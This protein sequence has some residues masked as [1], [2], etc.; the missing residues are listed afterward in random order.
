MVALGKL[1]GIGWYRSRRGRDGP[2]QLYS[3]I[4]MAGELEGHRNIDLFPDLKGP[5]KRDVFRRVSVFIY[6]RSRYRDGRERLSVLMSAGPLVE[7]HGIA[8]I[9]R[10]KPV[11]KPSAGWATRDLNGNV[12]GSGCKFIGKRLSRLRAGS[13]RLGGSVDLIRPNRQIGRR[14]RPTP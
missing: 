5:G 9:V 14:D 7:G 1:F 6:G 13:I 12:S 2:A 3:I 4:E 11:F 8:P 10:S